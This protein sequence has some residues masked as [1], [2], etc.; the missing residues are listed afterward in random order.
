M[1]SLLYKILNQIIIIQGTSPQKNP[2]L[3]PPPYAFVIIT[4][5]YWRMAVIQIYQSKITEDRAPYVR[6]LFHETVNYV[7]FVQKISF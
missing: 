2:Q 3:P 1:K 5:W 6:V 7:F 4:F